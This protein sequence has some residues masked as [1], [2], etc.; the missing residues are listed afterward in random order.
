MGLPDDKLFENLP[1]GVEIA[2]EKFFY[3][4]NMN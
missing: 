4:M 3:H 2:W 1:S